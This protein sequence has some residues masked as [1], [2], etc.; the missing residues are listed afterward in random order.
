MS[1]ANNMMKCPP[2]YP[3]PSTGLTS[4]KGPPCALGYYCPGGTVNPT[5]NPCPAG[6]YS[7]SY[8]TTNQYECCFVQEVMV[9]LLELLNPLS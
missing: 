1:S 4:F 2:S 9:A 5:D 7:N 6:T 8:Y 3:C